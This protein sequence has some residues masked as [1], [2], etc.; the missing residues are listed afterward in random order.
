VGSVNEKPSEQCHCDP[1]DVG[2]V[3]HHTVANIP[4][5]PA[6]EG[7]FC[8]TF[9]LQEEDAINGEECPGGLDWRL[10]AL[11]QSARVFLNLKPT[12]SYGIITTRVD[13]TRVWEEHAPLSKDGRRNLWSSMDAWKAWRANRSKQIDKFAVVDRRSEEEVKA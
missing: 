3:Q 5:S 2:G 9:G 1:R 13:I 7:F 10:R 11:P 6:W 12:P 4:P 8:S